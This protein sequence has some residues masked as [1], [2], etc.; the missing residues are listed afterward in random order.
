[1]AWF[2]SRWRWALFNLSAL[3]IFVYVWTQG[4]TDWTH[5]DTNFDSGLE[6]G[7]W[8]IRFL[9]I[10]LAMTPLY[11]FLRW[12]SA[13]KLRKSA[14]LWAFAF[15]AAHFAR[16]AVETWEPSARYRTSPTPWQWLT[17]PMQLYIA[18]GL[19]GLILLSALAMTSNKWSMRRLGKNWKRLHRCV[20]AADIAVAVH[21]LLATS[22]SKKVMVEDPNA[23][24]E[25][26]L[27]LGVL[28]VLLVVRIPQ[29]RSLIQQMVA[30]RRPRLRPVEAIAPRVIP[31]HIPPP[32]IIIPLPHRAHEAT[33]EP[34]PASKPLRPL[35]NPHRE[36]EKVHS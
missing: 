11:T 32:Q 14:G 33:D 7:K 27:Y 20:Y 22:M 31:S 30:K 12:S 24:T 15:G 17:W 6:S 4:S 16:Y 26:R 29:V 1:M 34:T 2:T 25:L 18:L 23:E 3:A 36:R 35:P 21:A 28:A 8:G 10:C 9:L 13:L 5:V 19:C